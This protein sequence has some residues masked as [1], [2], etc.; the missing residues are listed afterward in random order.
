M[1]Y[2]VE[3]GVHLNPIEQAIAAVKSFKP[4]YLLPAGI[5]SLTLVWIGLIITILMMQG[6]SDQNQKLP[7]PIVH[8]KTSSS[9]G[10]SNA[11][12]NQSTTSDSNLSVGVA[13]PDTR[14]MSV[15]VMKMPANIT[16]VVQNTPSV[17]SVAADNP[18]VN[19]PVTGGI[20]GSGGGD[21]SMPIVP[22]APVTPVTPV[23]P[24][25]PAAPALPIDPV[26]T[27]DPGTGL[28]TTGSNPPNDAAVK[29]S[30]IVIN[31]PVTS[32]VININVTTPAL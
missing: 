14:P 8:A 32:P 17:T 20:G 28:T 3:H 4:R 11:S 22:V 24:A 6:T 15:S 25:T 19:N 21:T 30:P 12:N 1:I 29:L 13:T 7:L 5:S 23:D 26:I 27:T 31:I 9:S 2:T 18:T 10:A 16:T